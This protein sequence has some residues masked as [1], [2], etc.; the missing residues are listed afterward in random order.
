[1]LVVGKLKK[2]TDVCTII[3]N[4]FVFIDVKILNHNQN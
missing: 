2:V 4:M 1:M 3:L